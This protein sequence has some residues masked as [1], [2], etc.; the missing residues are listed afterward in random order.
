MLIPS[1]YI[2]TSRTTTCNTYDSLSCLKLCKHNPAIPLYLFL[3]LRHLSKKKKRKKLGTDYLCLLGAINDETEPD[4]I[5]IAEVWKEDSWI[6]G[7][8]KTEMSWKGKSCRVRA[9]MSHHMIRYEFGSEGYDAIIK[10]LSMHI[11]ESKC[12]I[13]K[14]PMWF[15]SW[16]QQS[17]KV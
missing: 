11:D 10:R 15:F 13:S 12:L 2:Q 4:N 1:V 6:R 8:T 14:R 16:L 9:G 7:W 3:W 5:F 17:L